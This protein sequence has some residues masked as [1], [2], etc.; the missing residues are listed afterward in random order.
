MG[1]NVKGYGF[2]KMENGNRV[3]LTQLV[4]EDAVNTSLW[5]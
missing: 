2:R 1:K 5:A 4:P 3:G